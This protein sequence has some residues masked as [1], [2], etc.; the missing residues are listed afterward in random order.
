VTL[1]YDATALAALLAKGGSNFSRAALTNPNG[2]AG[3]DGIF[4]LR[5]DGTVQRGL[6][7]DQVTPEG[8]RLL[9]PAPAT[10]AGR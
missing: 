9:D 8:G 4:R 7:I 1:A 5:E 6:A 10:F 2:F 3:V